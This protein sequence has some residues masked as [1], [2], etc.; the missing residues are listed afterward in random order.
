MLDALRHDLRYALR[1]LRRSPGFAAAAI[2]TLA[3]GVGANTAMFSMFNSL[4]LRPLPIPDP[5][6]LIGVSSRNAQGQLRLTL[7]SAIPEIEK[8]GPFT[9]FCGFNGG[10][11]FPA[12]VNGTPTQTVIS[13][14]TGH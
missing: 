12:D 9:A 2:L 10:G 11:V 7:I 6:G 1:H 3:L 14:V 5:D 8:D 13:I 4:V